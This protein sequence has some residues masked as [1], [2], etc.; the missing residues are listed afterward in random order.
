MFVFWH[1]SSIWVKIRLR[2]ENKLPRW[3]GSS[4]NCFGGW[5]GVGSDRPITLSLQL[6][7]VE[8]GCDNNSCSGNNCKAAVYWQFNPKHLVQLYSKLAQ[9]CATRGGIAMRSWPLLLPTFG[10]SFPPF[11]L[12]QAALRAPPEAG[13]QL[14]RIGGL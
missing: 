6:E 12:P 10:L 3:S 5:S 14:A 4:L 7:W 1:E 8:L 2:A 11:F 9:A 13:F